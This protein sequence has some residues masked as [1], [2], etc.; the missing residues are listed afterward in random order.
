MLGE[1]MTRA[2]SKQLKDHQ[3]HILF[4]KN[5]DLDTLTKIEPDYRLRRYK[6]TNQYADNLSSMFILTIGHCSLCG[7]NNPDALQVHHID[8]NHQHNDWNNV[9]VICANCHVLIHKRKFD[10]WEELNLKK[11]KTSCVDL[12]TKNV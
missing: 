10:Y 2:K 5:S 9:T 6:Q 12:T 4:C 7:F 3:H 8:F 1:N 11:L